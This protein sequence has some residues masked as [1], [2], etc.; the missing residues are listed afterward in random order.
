M[1]PGVTCLTQSLLPIVLVGEGSIKACLI[2]GQ[3]GAKVGVVIVYAA[4]SRWC[5]TKPFSRNLVGLSITYCFYTS[6]ICV[7]FVYL[8]F[9]VLKPGLHVLFI[10]YRVSL[11]PVV[12]E[13]FF[14][15][16]LLG[17][18][19]KKDVSVK[20]SRFIY[21]RTSQPFAVLM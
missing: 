14:S 19:P 15:E 10:S 17:L 18:H 4:S 13:K 6:P 16:L 7:S 12:L 1:A 5:W 3:G 9:A 11:H 21:C 20:G 8:I 2:L